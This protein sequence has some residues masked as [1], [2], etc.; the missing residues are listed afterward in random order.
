MNEIVNE[1]E[2]AW[3]LEVIKRRSERHRFAEDSCESDQESEQMKE[4][5]V[6]EFMRGEWQSLARYA[7]K[8]HPQQ[9]LG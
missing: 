4:Y 7:N 5:Q 2:V 3:Q 1:E 8:V 6:S 9:Y